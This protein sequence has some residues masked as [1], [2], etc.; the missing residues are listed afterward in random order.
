MWHSEQ[1]KRQKHLVVW[2]QHNRQ[3]LW[4]KQKICIF[5]S[6]QS[7]FFSFMHNCPSFREI[8]KAPTSAQ[9]PVLLHT[10]VVLWVFQA[11]K[12]GNHWCRINRPGCDLR[13]IVPDNV[14]TLTFLLRGA[15]LPGWKIRPPVGKVTDWAYWPPL[16]CLI[17][18]CV[19]VCVCRAP[20]ACVFTV[21][22]VCCW[23]W[24]HTALIRPLIPGCFQAA[25]LWEWNET[26]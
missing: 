21:Y 23:V 11:E 17:G 14:L 1:F 8:N 18:V 7:Y 9:D 26:L 19:C 13:V 15:F 4:L 25:A 6:R 5:Y 3:P 10:S 16:L 12:V 22:N 2:P 24:T 20:W